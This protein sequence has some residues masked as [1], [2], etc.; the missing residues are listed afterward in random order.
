MG[1][2]LFLTTAKNEKLQEDKELREYGAL[3]KKKSKEYEKPEEKREPEK[4]KET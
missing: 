3:G 4:N 1:A 2:K